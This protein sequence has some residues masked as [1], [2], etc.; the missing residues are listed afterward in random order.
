MTIINRKKYYSFM[1]RLLYILVFLYPVFCFANNIP[2]Y[3]Y[4]IK[5]NSISRILDFQAVF[6]VQFDE[7]GRGELT[8]PGNIRIDVKKIYS[9]VDG[10]EENLKY[11]DLPNKIVIKNT[12]YKNK[13]LDI[14]INFKVK[15]LVDQAYLLLK[16]YLVFPV[17]VLI[18]KTNSKN[19]Q[20]ISHQYQ[21]ELSVPQNWYLVNTQLSYPEKKGKKWIFKIDQITQSCPVLVIG[22]NLDTL[23]YSQINKNL[24][25]I[26]GRKNL[27]GFF[28]DYSSLSQIFYKINDLKEYVE[29]VTGQSFSDHHFQF[30]LMNLTS[31]S[32]PTDQSII[33]S[34]KHLKSLLKDKDSPYIYDIIHDLVMKLLW[35]KIN[36]LN[37]DSDYWII[38]GI[39]HYIAYYYFYENYGVTVEYTNS[40]KFIHF[41]LGK[42][43][44]R[45]AKSAAIYQELVRYGSLNKI[46][47]DNNDRI[48]DHSYRSSTINDHYSLQIFM[49]IKNYLGEQNFHQF[50]NEYL[51][52]NQHNYLTTDNLIKKI[53][54]YISS[55]Q[56]QGFTSLIMDYPKVDFI[57]KKNK[58]QIYILKKKSAL[59]F[60]VEI[61]I[62]YKNKSKKRLVM[63]MDSPIKS[64]PIDHLQDVK[65]IVID[66]DRLLVEVNKR[67]NF[68]RLPVHFSILAPLNY[69]DTYNLSPSG[70][71]CTYDQVSLFG[72]TMT[73]GWNMSQFT[74]NSINRP[75]LLWGIDAGYGYEE[76]EEDD[77]YRTL[78][79]EHNAFVHLF[80]ENPVYPLSIW[81]P[82][83][84]N[85]LF[86]VSG[87]SISVK[88]GLQS[89][90]PPV[91]KTRYDRLYFNHSFDAGFDLKLKW[92]PINSFE[93]NL[94]FGYRLYLKAG[95]YS[96]ESILACNFEFDYTRLKNINLGFH[97]DTKLDLRIF[98]AG[99]R[100]GFLLGFL[101]Y[102]RY[103]YRRP[104][105]SR[106]NLVTQTQ[107]YYEMIAKNLTYASNLLIDFP[108]PK[109][110]FLFTSVYCLFKINFFREPLLDP[111]ISVGLGLY[112]DITLPLPVERDKFKA[113]FVG[114]LLKI[115]IKKTTSV[116]IKT[117]FLPMFHRQGR[118][119][120]RYPP[121]GNI[122]VMI[123]Y[124][125]RITL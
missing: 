6:P 112:S 69:T 101:P 81:S 9:I 39:A 4:Q 115:D 54:N 20:T 74:P 50:L 109:M 7:Q 108:Y 16:K 97:L 107:G 84:Y 72:V 68:L 62:T 116:I 3:H 48:I 94:N 60:P 29:R 40:H 31:L 10:G 53:G 36:P 93:Y 124:E 1:K 120:F 91:K 58:I 113:L 86:F 41:L 79:D 103:G 37:G 117:A 24:Y 67:N 66:P 118:L 44:S 17:Q 19:D 88:S 35:K 30:I 96:M 106:L 47:Q 65:N 57:L 123:F 56:L 28:A 100:P 22:K 5:F 75:S 55:E 49:N 119:N 92:F 34:V 122:L 2:T 125:I 63:I 111:R 64:I 76:M 27:K 43:Q 87:E 23:A 104:Y 26:V 14:R 38:E 33:I 18:P 78:R 52:E 42:K 121:N 105:F 51:M 89:F 32:L 82:R 73:G 59:T 15:I 70:V 61:E 95:L 102:E 99:I 77:D 83:I 71:L 85:S 25:Q 45:Y 110:N 114:G 13:K 46:T 12:A 90:I 98:E 80:L 8:K 21:I 11:R